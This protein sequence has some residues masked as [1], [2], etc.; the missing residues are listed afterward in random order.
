MKLFVIIGDCITKNS[1]ANL[2][3]LA[4]IRG[5]LNAGH[6]VT[7]LS[8]DGKG[9]QLD[10]YMMIQEDVKHYT[11]CGISLY[12]KLSL[13]KKRKQS[14]LKLLDKS[15]LEA[16]KINFDIKRKLKEF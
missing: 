1:S 5:L 12:E 8:A 9:Y 6:D 2:C 14:S 11:Y 7:L 13:Y 10:S 15:T 16:E 3:H 4:Y